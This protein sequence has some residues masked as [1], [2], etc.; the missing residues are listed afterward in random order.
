M[1]GKGKKR[2]AVGGERNVR[3]YQMDLKEGSMGPAVQYKLVGQGE[4]LGHWV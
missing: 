2:V 3:I 4:V 1:S